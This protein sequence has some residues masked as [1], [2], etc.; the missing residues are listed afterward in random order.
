MT[1]QVHEGLLSWFTELERAL[2][3][4][5]FELVSVDLRSS[6]ETEHTSRHWPGGPQL[7]QRQHSLSLE[8]TAQDRLARPG[9]WAT[10]HAAQTVLEGLGLDVDEIG[11]AGD[12]IKINGC[13]IILRRDIDPWSSKKN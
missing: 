7:L 12:L 11:L 3:E 6:L 5:G 2:F 1:S 8:V 9:G 10:A 4:A 13:A